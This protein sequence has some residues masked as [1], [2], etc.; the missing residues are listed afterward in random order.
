MQSMKR[1]KDLYGLGGGSNLKSP[2]ALT[3]HRKL[4]ALPPNFQ[5]NKLY[6]IG[7]RRKTVHHGSNPAQQPIQEG[8]ISELETKLNK[9]LTQMQV[10]MTGK[11]PL[12]AKEHEIHIKNPQVM[13]FPHRQN[14]S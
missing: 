6:P 10:E 7:E 1:M 4:K 14:S 5:G 3:S 9:Q 11:T 12:I 8:M 2:M 13:H